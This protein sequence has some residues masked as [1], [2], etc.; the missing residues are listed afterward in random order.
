MDAKRSR[1]HKLARLL[2]KELSPAYNVSV[3]IVRR[4]IYQ[5]SN[6]ER[7]E[8]SGISWLDLEQKKFHIH[9]AYDDCLGCML[10]SLIHEWSH[11]LDWSHLHDMKEEPEYHSA[12]FGVW[13]AKV[14]R[15][16]HN[17]K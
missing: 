8:C 17:T 2:K 12:T 1:I 13:Y 15:I 16:I 6:D 11:I 7:Y 14:Y 10:D 3:R 4:K 5:S 9:I